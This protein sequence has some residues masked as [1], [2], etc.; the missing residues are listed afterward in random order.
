[1]KYEFEA[2]FNNLFQKDKKNLFSKW[3]RI[4]NHA[5]YTYEYLHRLTT[6]GDL[7]WVNFTY[8][9]ASNVWTLTPTEDVIC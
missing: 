8:C 2:F 7:N 5:R 3:Y 6:P 9:L 1:M 4:S